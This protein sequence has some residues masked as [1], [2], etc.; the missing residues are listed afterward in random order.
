MR[1]IG[2]GLTMPTAHTLSGI[3]PFLKNGK[4][5]P[6]TEIIAHRGLI[7]LVLVLLR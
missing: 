1:L 4:Y 3:L 2:H 5:E 6:R 7:V